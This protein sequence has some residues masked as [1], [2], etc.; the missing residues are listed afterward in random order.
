MY[1][2]GTLAV[3]GTL[4]RKPG[5]LLGLAFLIQIM[6]WPDSGLSISFI[7]SYLALG[8]ILTLGEGFYGLFRGTI[9]ELISR[10]LSASLGAFIATA[11]VSAAFFGALKPIGIFAGLLVV[12]LITVFMI[13]AMIWLVLNCLFP[14][15]SLPAGFVLSAVYGILS[16]LIQAAGRAPGIEGAEPRMVF[17]LSAAAAVLILVW[18]NRLKLRTDLA[19]FA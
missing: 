17:V 9:P 8:G 16:R 7:L 14:L 2:L 12:P 1:F 5:F 11:G 6:I 15:L 19:P 10:P 13:A 3:L 4:P 18:M